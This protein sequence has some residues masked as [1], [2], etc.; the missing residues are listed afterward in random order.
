MPVEQ[1][2]AT[3][4]RLY[5][6]AWNKGN[7][8]VIPELVSPDYHYG[9]YK[10][11]DGYRQLV[12]TQRSAFPDVHFTIDQ[13][14]GEGDWLAYQITTK[15]TLKGKL[16]DIEPTGKEATWKRAFFSQFKDGKLVAAVAVADNLSFYQQIGVKPPGF[17]QSVEQNK[18]TLKR[19]YDEAWNKGNLAVVPE[20]VSPDYLTHTA[21]RDFKGLQGYRDNVTGQRTNMPD[22][23][24]TIE[25]IV[26]EGDKLAYRITGHGTYKGK[27]GDVDVTGKQFT[28]TQVLFA[29]Y[30]D[31]KVAKA[32]ST[33]DMLDIYRQAG[34]RPPGFDQSIEQNKTVTRRTLEDVMNKGNVAL[35]PELFAANYVFHVRAGAEIKGHDGWKQ[36]VVAGRNAFPDVVYTVIELAGEGDK[37]FCRFSW[38]GTHKGDYSGIAPT[39]KRIT[40]SGMFVNRFEG[41]KVVETW[42][43]SNPLL[44]YQ[45]MGVAPPGFELAKK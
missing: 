30:K 6:E 11:V 38:T 34:V 37:V 36:V 19:L 39:G 32:V 40:G 9:E 42:G 7:L 23:H 31:G 26:G 16:L 13:V 33:V 10:G 29:E 24:F 1:N 41:A 43:E 35:I 4:R 8:A 45:Q 22:L 28:Y 27:L 21:Q 3:L 18:A 15:G 5:E 17:D 12:T 25:E 2:K 20:L 44:M 14:I